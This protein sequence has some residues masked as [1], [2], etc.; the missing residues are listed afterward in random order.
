MKRLRMNTMHR[1]NCSKLKTVLFVNGL[2]RHLITAMEQ[3]VTAAIHMERIVY[4]IILYSMKRR[5]DVI[6]SWKMGRNRRFSDSEGK[7]AIRATLHH[8]I[9]LRGFYFV[10]YFWRCNFCFVRRI[11]FLSSQ[12]T[13]CLILQTSKTLLSSLRCQL[14]PRTPKRN[15]QGP[16][17]RH[18]IER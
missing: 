13:L 4:L 18:L 14:E 7:S 8:T 2:S 17:P 6:G 10:S 12:K 3:G 9:Q 16:K 15:K 5:V 11:S 1:I